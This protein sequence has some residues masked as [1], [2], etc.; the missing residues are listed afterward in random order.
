MGGAPVDAAVAQ[1]LDR[2]AGAREV[3]APRTARLDAAHGGAAQAAALALEMAAALQGLDH[4]EPAAVR[5][6]DLGARDRTHWRGVSANRE[7][8]AGAHACG[9]TRPA[10]PCGAADGPR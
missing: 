2:L 5:E 9:P 8:L 7:A 1:R 10:W 4:V 6:G 3:H